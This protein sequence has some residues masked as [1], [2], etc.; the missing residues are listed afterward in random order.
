[1]ADESGR[2]EGAPLVFPLLLIALGL[3]FLYASWRPAFDPWAVLKA[4]WPLGLILLGLGKIW[5]NRHDQPGA[6][7][8]GAGALVGMLLFVL[9]IVALV[10]HGRGRG[11]AMDWSGGRSTSHTSESVE[12]KG[13]TS[14]RE[15]IE[16][17]AGQ[18]NIEGGSSR[19]LDADFRFTN[20]WAAPRVD[21][22]VSNGIGDM[23]IS[24][25]SGGPHIGS[26]QNSWRLRMNPEV[27]TELK[28]TL[29]AGQSNLD[30][31]GVNLTRLEL[32]MGAGQAQIDLRGSR[33]SDLDG[34]IEG[35][36]GQAVLRLPKDVGVIATASGGIGSI[37]I[38]GLTKNGNDEY[39]NAA[40]GKSPH[41]I[42]L[43]VEGGI[44]SIQL[45][46]EP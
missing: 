9:V 24:Q 35:G 30:L 43:R 42:H 8:S 1:M 4:W 14:V 36:V 28:V 25:E 11:R 16:M 6:G 19:L 40:Y 26:S 20:S 38:S 39:T 10:W 15:S 29:G 22:Y 17:S 31:K 13:A 46:E 33:K 32:E 3:I 12:L 2:R 41:T 27:P 34:R 23:T 44:G 7:R 45:L 37:G 5:D 21:Y 18:L